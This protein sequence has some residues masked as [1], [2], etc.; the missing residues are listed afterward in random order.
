MDIHNGPYE[1]TVCGLQ[2]SE[3]STVQ[4]WEQCGHALRQVDEARQW[5]IGDWLCDGKRHYGDSLYERAA[6]VTGLEEKTLRNLKSLAD[7]FELSRRRDKLGWNKHEAVAGI[8]LTGSNTDGTLGITEEPDAAAIQ[9]LLSKAEKHKW[10]VKELRGAV[11]EHKERQREHIRLANE[12]DKYTVIYADPPW[13]YGDE[14][15]HATGGA[16]AQYPLMSLSEICGIPVQRLTATDAVLFLWVTAPLLAE[17][18][19][20][21]DS[22]GFTYKTHLVW[23]K[24][25][26]FYG[27]YSHVQH[28]LLCICTRGSCTPTDGAQLPKSVI[29]IP[30]EQHSAKPHEFYEIIDE[31]YPHGNRIEL[32]ARNRRD[33]WDAWGNEVNATA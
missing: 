4:Q 9:G 8:K 18:M 31:L 32:F 11:R 7:K 21:I 24:G 12:P 27:N 25:R 22:W 16:A 17:S 14:R 1:L 13:Q 28:E 2:L 5:A 30:R 6:A 3:K 15:N 19:S 20:V 10:T 29:A 23:D 26:P 33:N